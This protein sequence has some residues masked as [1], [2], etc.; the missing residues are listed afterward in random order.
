MFLQMATK[1]SRRR[2]VDTV[3]CDNK[4][5]ILLLYKGIT[6]GVNIDDK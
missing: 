2:I 6:N 3:G 4:K 1:Q 5:T